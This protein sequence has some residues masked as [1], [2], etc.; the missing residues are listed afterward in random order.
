[1]QL[2]LNYALPPAL[3]NEETKHKFVS[4][5]HS[6]HTSTRCKYN[7]RLLSS[8]CWSWWVQLLLAEGSN[9]WWLLIVVE[10]EFFVMEIVS[11]GHNHTCMG[12]RATHQRKQLS[13]VSISTYILPWACPPNSPNRTTHTIPPTHTHTTPPQHTT[14]H[15]TCMSMEKVLWGHVVS[16][17]DNRTT[18]LRK[19][20][21]KERSSIY[22]LSCA[23][24]TYTYIHSR[25]QTHMHKSTQWCEWP[26]VI[27]WLMWNTDIE[28]W[29]GWTYTNTAHQ[30]S[31]RQLD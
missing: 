27:H 9:Y 5:L 15:H 8:I 12:S 11:Y 7:I 19:Q 21:S 13:E 30:Q 1:M 16:C 23:C 14:S 31:G 29:D 26:K 20:E 28:P 24:Q 3:L 25:M 2:A 4:C 18:P 10:N 6:H 17:L 22:T